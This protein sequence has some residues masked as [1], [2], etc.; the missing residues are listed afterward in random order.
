MEQEYEG[1]TREMENIM[2]LNKEEKEQ[3]DENYIKK[4]HSN[5]NEDIL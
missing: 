3:R 5:L 1:K 2:L 4:D